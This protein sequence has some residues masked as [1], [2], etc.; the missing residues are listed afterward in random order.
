MPSPELAAILAHVP[1]DFADPSADHEHVRRTF[2]PFHGHPVR[3]ELQVD[4]PALGGVRCGRYTDATLPSDARILFHC[5]GGAF[6]SCPLDV[7]HFYADM[8]LR[9]T[10]SAVVMRSPVACKTL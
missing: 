5:H 10:G 9:Y 4:F 7:Y 3:P 6:V 1:A 2:A 8:L